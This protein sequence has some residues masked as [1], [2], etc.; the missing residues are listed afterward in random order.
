MVIGGSG[1]FFPLA[2]TVILLEKSLRERGSWR[3][4]PGLAAKS[5]PCRTLTCG[6]TGGRFCRS[7]LG[8]SH[9]KPSL[10]GQDAR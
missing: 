6:L 8:A 3:D 10:E 1:D 9:K 5:P 7:H 4:P 2:D